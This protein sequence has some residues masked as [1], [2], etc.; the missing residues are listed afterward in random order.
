MEKTYFH[1]VTL[2]K[3]KCMGC[4]NCLKRCPTEAIRVRSGKARIIKERCIDCGE[5]IRVCP[6]HAKKAVTDPFAKTEEYK[7]KIA[8]PAPSLY[9]QFNQLD[10]INI[11]L[12][13]LKKIGF[14][15][16]YEVARAA[17]IV[18]IASKDLIF[19]KK[20][21]YPIISSACPAVVRLIRV[22]F[23]NLI[24]NLLPVLSPM[25]VAAKLA[26][27]EA[28]KK[29]GLSLDEIGAFFITPCAAKMTV[30]KDPLGQEKSYVDG[31]ISMSDIYMRL[32]SAMS[33]V[34]NP[35]NLVRSGL[36][37]VGW[38]SSGG[39]A[40]ALGKDE[41]IAVDGI[42]N[43][44]KVFEGLEDEQ[45]HNIK[46]IE[47]G[48]C[49]GGC[50]GGPL[51]VENGFVAETKIKLLTKML[52]SYEMEKAFPCI[53]M[54]DVSFTKDI[55]YIPVMKLD[56]DISE[57]MK[58]MERLERIYNSMPKIDCGSCGAPSCR[59]LAEDIVRG[60]GKEMDCVHKL[61]ER[62]FSLA[63]E[64]VEIQEN[65]TLSEKGGK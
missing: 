12:N 54:E 5:C 14:D 64:M 47:A 48:A 16:V 61:R 25:E 24:K 22:R 33:K 46:F 57:A 20:L 28:Q 23:P 17:E 1:S 38:A 56:S 9:G 42:D 11:V 4:T 15:D 40:Y 41:Y 26:K 7:Y 45:F 50:V 3:D 21:Q 59:A 52:T 35:E 18:T 65:I 53:D 49:V 19:Q 37:G 31:A 44:I 2:D 60:F 30:I 43:V 27:K 32:V 34:D 6:Y 62:V 8:L 39:E 10:D 63:K 36:K 55:E 13:G 51:A 58:K 29:T